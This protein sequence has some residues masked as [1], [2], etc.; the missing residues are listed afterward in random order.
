MSNQEDEPMIIQS[1]EQQTD[2][3][4]E[5]KIGRLTVNK[6]TRSTRIDGKPVSL[7]PAEFDLLWFLAAR[8]GCTVTRDELYQEILQTNY[9]GL[10][11]CL[12]LRISRI[13]KKLGDNRTSTHY[14]KSIRSEGYLLVRNCG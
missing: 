1:L 14:I 13:R 8:A 5:I 2:N 10:N 4:H 3:G 6:Q 11:R 9:D 7:S 12:D